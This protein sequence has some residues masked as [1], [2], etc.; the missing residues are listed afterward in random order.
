MASSLLEQRRV[1]SF[2]LFT[3]PLISRR[4][5]IRHIKPQLWMRWLHSFLINTKLLQRHDITE[6]TSPLHLPYL[7][8]YII[9][10]VFTP[11]LGERNRQFL[12]YK[13]L[14]EKKEQNILNSDTR[15][16]EMF[17]PYKHIKNNLHMLTLVFHK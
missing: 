14:E 8:N 15:P 2:V 9:W 16:N 1:I 6:R 17:T 12:L 11:Q 3:R 13:L 7:E 10:A 4:T 5:M